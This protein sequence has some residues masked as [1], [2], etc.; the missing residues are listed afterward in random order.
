MIG[1]RKWYLDG[2]HGGVW[3]ARSDLGWSGTLGPE[4]EVLP[5]EA[6]AAQVDAWFPEGWGEEGAGGALLEI[7]LALGEEPFSS[8]GSPAGY[9]KRI[10]RRALRDGRL[11]AVRPRVDAPVGSG[12]EAT[13]EGAAT[14]PSAPREDKTWIEIVLMDD[15]DPPKAVPFRRYRVE[16]PDGSAREGALDAYGRAMLVGID[17]GTCQVSF[18]DFDEKDWGRA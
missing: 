13:E 15:D 17:P 12:P 18:P 7:G 5:R 16:L 14:G 2:L 6:A 8:G 4:G 3:L 1:S 11:V 10:V 9:L